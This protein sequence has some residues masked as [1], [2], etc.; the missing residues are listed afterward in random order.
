MKKPIIKIFDKLILLLLGF[1]GMFYSCYKYG[2]PIAT[3]EINGIVTD[4]KS[5][6][7][8][9]IRVVRQTYYDSNDTLYTN[10]EGK[11]YYKYWDEVNQAYLTIEDIDGEA[12]GGEF[13]PVELTVKFSDADRVNKKDN[14]YAKTIGIILRTIDD[15]EYVVE[16]GVP[17]APFKP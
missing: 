8:Q 5:K 11:F 1:S 16:Y 2:M 10:S 4:K 9:D 15:D 12:N 13:K 14:K 3:Y 7:I 17:R 6:P